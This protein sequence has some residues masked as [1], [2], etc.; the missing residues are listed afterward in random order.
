[1]NDVLSKSVTHKLCAAEESTEKP[2]GRSVISPRIYLFNKNPGDLDADLP[3][4]R[5]HSS[6]IQRARAED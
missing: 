6:R 4:F 3:N 5:K 1:M 2:T